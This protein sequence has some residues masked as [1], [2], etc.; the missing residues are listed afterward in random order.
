MRKTVIIVGGSGK[1]GGF[2]SNYLSKK[3]KFEI[4]IID[5]VK[6][7]DNKFDKFIKF[8]LLNFKKYKN[9]KSEILKKYKSIDILINCAAMV[10]T[11]QDKGW[12]K[13]FEFQSVLSW[14]KC[15]DTN[16]T[17]IFLII[18]TL[19]SLLK[20]SKNPKIINISSIY[21]FTAPRFEIYKNSKIKNQLAYAVS[22]AGVIQLT[23]WLS[24]YLDKKFSINTIS[25]GGLS[26]KYMKKSF[27]QNYSK[28]TF[29][30]RMLKLED[31]IPSIDYLISSEYI[32]GQNIIVD[33]G[34]S[35]Y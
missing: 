16:L 1:I 13:G 15:L 10:G 33:G 2:I 19:L 18:Q 26:D 27:K 20:K 6:P 11:N 5:K 9:L 3:N 24:S 23:K 31:V 25:F 7:K 28:H 34:W 8:D 12:R 4:V 21:G 35:V 29:K 32:T 14:Q 22:K 30:K 17:S